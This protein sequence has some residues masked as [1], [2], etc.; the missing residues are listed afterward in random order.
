MRLNPE[1]IHRLNPEER[2]RSF[3]EMPGLIR[4]L[5]RAGLN[6]L[7]VQGVFDIVH[8][9]HTGLLQATRRIDPANSVVVVGLENDDTVRRNKGNRRPVNPLDDR[10]RV[11]AEFRSVAYAFGYDD[12]PRYDHPED[13]L[14]RWRALSPAAVVAATWDPHRNLKEW[15]ADEAGTQLALV[16]YQH[17]NSTTRMLRTVGYEE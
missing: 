11:M 15:Q 13:Y 8:A 4:E 17:E 9:G 3:D 16:D 12:V 6:V 1:T 10:L 14:E 2:I 5:G 7:L